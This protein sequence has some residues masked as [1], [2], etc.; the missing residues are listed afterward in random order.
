MNP[1]PASPPRRGRSALEAS[2]GPAPGADPADTH[3]IEPRALVQAGRWLQSQHYRFV[4]PTPATH[5]VVLGQRSQSR[6]LADDLRDV[7]GW[8]LPLAPGLLPADVLH[9]LQH[10][11]MVQHARAGPGADGGASAGLLRAAVR[12]STLGP[13]ILAHSP[14]PT[15]QNDA[16]FLGPDTY[17]FAALIRRELQARPLGRG[18]RILDMGCGTGAGG[19]VAA[20]CAQVPAQQLVLADI[21]AA[22]LRCARAGAELAGLAGAQ[23]CQ[24][25]LFSAVTGAFDLIVANPPYLNDGA[26]RLYRHG[27]GRWGEALSLRIVRE[28]VPHLAP[29]GRLVLY[30]GSA[31]SGGVDP[32]QRAFEAERAALGGSW[33]YEEI[34]PDVFGEELRHPAYA[35]VDRIAAVGLVVR[36]P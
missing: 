12:F 21:S 20:H 30:T 17:R 28:G 27:G 3:P 10:A 19:L 7:F 13:L 36:R 18:A 34:D 22:A 33:S 4:T 25:D 29:G 14:F 15:V 16:V 31:V 8:N 11:G 24:G 35:G 9:R 2:A 5:A 6:P 26:G 32:L 23:L 1:Q